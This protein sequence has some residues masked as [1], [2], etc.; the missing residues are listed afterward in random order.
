MS[1]L[2]NLLLDN[3]IKNIQYTWSKFWDIV[4]CSKNRSNFYFS[5]MATKI[6]E[7]F[8]YWSP[9]LCIESLPSSFGH[10]RPKN[11]PTPFH[12]ENMWLRHKSFKQNMKTWWDED[13]TAGNT[14]QTQE[15]KR[16]LE[17]IESID[18]WKHSIGKRKNSSILFK[19]LPIEEEIFLRRKGLLGL[20]PKKNFR[21]LFSG[22]KLIGVKN[23]E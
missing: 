20:K 5:P 15:S 3:P 17:E 11:G 6:P 18:I 4:A 13:V 2:W 22:K 12:L 21:K 10:R 23:Q 8:S 9:S 16:K 19:T 7:E 14:K 1:E